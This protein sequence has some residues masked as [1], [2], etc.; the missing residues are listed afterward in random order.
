M[1]LIG[2][3]QAGNGPWRRSALGSN[4]VK[5]YKCKRTQLC[6]F[7]CMEFT[8]SK[9]PEGIHGQKITKV[10]T[11]LTRKTIFLKR[12]LQKNSARKVF[13]FFEKKSPVT[14]IVRIIIFRPYFIYGKGKYLNQTV[15]F[16]KICQEFIY[17]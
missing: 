2:E 10:V 5:V 1:L 12:K 14:H 16:Y 7:L 8:V 3:K 6:K 15:F 4:R 11:L 13:P 17:I 9:I